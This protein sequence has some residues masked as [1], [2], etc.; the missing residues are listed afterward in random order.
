MRYLITCLFV[1]ACCV[2]LV[3][4]PATKDSSSQTKG[5]DG[6]RTKGKEGG[7]K[8]LNVNSSPD[9]FTIKEGDTHDIKVSITRQ[10]TSWDDDVIIKFKDL[11]KGVTAPN[12]ARIAK[13]SA[14]A[15][16]KL[17]AAADA[18]EVSNTGALLEA[19]SD[20]ITAK[21]ALTITVKKK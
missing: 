2:S 4:C 18:G 20:G 11:P 8:V 21:H 6:S 5:T 1:V 17:A 12:D 9:S 14:S 3:G 10:P 19:M 16:F 15:T 13:G 7:E